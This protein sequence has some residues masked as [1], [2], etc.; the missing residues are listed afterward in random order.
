[1]GG[2]NGFLWPGA[3]LSVRIRIRLSLI[4]CC[5]RLG[6]NSIRSRFRGNV[7]SAGR[8]CLGSFGIRTRPGASRSG[9]PARGTARGASGSGTMLPRI[10]DVDD[11]W[12]AAFWTDSPTGFFKVDAPLFWRL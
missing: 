2:G 4:R 11:A 10:D 6:G 12:S 8:G 9:S 5:I 7:R 3:V 1:M